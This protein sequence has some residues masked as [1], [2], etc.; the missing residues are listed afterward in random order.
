MED[1]KD[2]QI[3]TETNHYE[4]LMGIFLVKKVKNNVQNPYCH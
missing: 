4:V 1:T 2:R 3:I